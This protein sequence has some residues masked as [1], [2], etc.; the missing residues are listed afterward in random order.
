MALIDYQVAD[1]IAR[2]GLNR[3]ARH[4]AL[5]PELL[6]ALRDALARARAAR[7]AAVV[8][9]A[10]GP[11]F[12]TGGDVRA[13]Y[14]TPRAERRGYADRV[15][16]TLND[17]ILDLLDMP[18]PTVAAVHG[19]V[20]GGSIGLV[21]A[22]DIAL[23]GPKASF[24]PWYTVVGFSPDGGWSALLPERI[25]RAR[26]LE[27]QLLNQRIDVDEAR[28]LGLVSPRVC[29]QAP[30]ATALEQAARIR[31]AQP[32]STGHTLA[33][34]RPNRVTVSRRLDAERRHF[35]DQ[36]ETDEAETGMAA[37]LGRRSRA[38]TGSNPS[39]P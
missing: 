20:T 12:S 2:V 23:A 10:E 36:I 8:V 29:E 18:C 15:V 6:D 25:G 19:A 27:V 7:P 39:N 1:G 14:D 4:N 32:R 21:L 26:A 24:A 16:G 5:V 31:Q 37:F 34:M 17:A 38:T 9:H 22:C 11:S 33:L 35:L 30:L 3:P 28:R 13:F